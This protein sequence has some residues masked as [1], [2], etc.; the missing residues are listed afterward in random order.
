M[1]KATKIAIIVGTGALLLGIIVLV[2]YLYSEIDRLKVGEPLA[3]IEDSRSTSTPATATSTKPQDTDQ[4]AKLTRQ[5]CEAAGGRWNPCG[6]LCRAEPPGTMCAE[7]CVEYCECGDEQDYTCPQGYSCVDLVPSPDDPAAVG[8]CKPSAGASNKQS[9]T[10]PDDWTSFVLPE[11]TNLTNPF[12][13]HGTTTAFENTVNWR[14]EDENG[15]TV[16]EGYANVMSPDIGEPGPFHVTAFFDLVPATKTGKL[17]VFEVSA[18]DGSEV[19]KATAEVS[20]PQESAT[21]KIYFGNSEKNEEGKECES[22]YPVE[23]MVVAGDNVAIAVH[24]LL[25]GPNPLEKK[26]GYFSSLPQDVSD[27]QINNKEDGIQLD[28][29]EDLQ[30]QVGGS[31]RVT[32]IDRQ[33]AKTALEVSGQDNVIIS[34]NGRTD[35]ILQP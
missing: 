19:H 25:K 4:P 9:F 18:R 11:G 22:V 29:D 28:F 2:R 27:P 15:I 32:H 26:S 10:S 34:I 17:H 20:L 6:S 23:R 7:V 21:V 1:K 35:N 30:Y 16:S 5:T 33:I 3:P 31:C 8:V 24:E 12:T 13:F 14:L